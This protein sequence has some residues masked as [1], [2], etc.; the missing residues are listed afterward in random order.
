MTQLFKMAF[1]DLG[2]NRRRT[3]FSMLAVGMGLALLLLMASFITGEIQGAFDRSIK[4]QSGDIQVRARTYNESK[5]SL[6][7]QDLVENPD[8]VAAQIASL[9]PVTV[10]TPRLYASGIIVSGDNSTGV[11]VVGIEPASPANAPFRDAMV[12]G[13]FI[14]ADDRAGILI[15]QSLANKIGVKS[16]DTV[17]LMVNTSNGGISQQNFTVRGIYNTH[18]PGYDDTTIF[19]PLAKAQAISD[20]QNY[21]STIFVLLKNKDQANAV[22][23]AL[24]GSQYQVQTWIQ[25]NDLIYQ[26]EQLS[27]AYMWLL[28]LIV[29]G[30]TA[31]VIINTLIMSV[32][33]RTREIGIL[34]AIGMKSSQIMSMFLAEST[35]LAV[36]GIVMGL[37]L[38]LLMVS[39]A[40][41]YGFYIGNFGVTGMTLG[42]TI[43]AS[44]TLNDAITLSVMAFIITLLA[45]LYPAILAAH[46]EP[47]QA[48]HGGK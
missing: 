31:T 37:I 33:E 23:N 48:L 2:R 14:T 12:S 7:Y 4:L 35:I 18:T 11:Q 19:M 45:A 27:N 20:T 15:G 24:Q 43:H 41:T 25:M 17:N 21:A 46:M 44:L 30:I 10:A 29:L 3:F 40:T 6:A 34:S 13:Q 39:Y 8:Q 42:D 5:A 16:G 28:Y 26:T 9:A 38:G 36:G 47:V 32:F 22:V 1:R